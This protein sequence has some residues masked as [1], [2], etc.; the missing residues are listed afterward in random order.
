MPSDL[1]T[2]EQAVLD[3]LREGHG[4][5]L[6]FEEEKIARMIV[7]ALDRLDEG[8][9]ER[10]VADERARLLGILW[11]EHGDAA[12]DSLSQAVFDDLIDMLAP[13]LQEP[14]PCSECGGSGRTVGWG[15][16]DDGNRVSVWRPCPSCGTGNEEDSRG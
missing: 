12:E 5:S 1:T 9:Y 8:E 14:G 13:T 4:V 10:G 15:K 11:Q 16:D 6:L 7:A 2:R 3:V